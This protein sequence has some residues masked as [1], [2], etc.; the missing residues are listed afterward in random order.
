MYDVSKNDLYAIRTYR[1]QPASRRDWYMPSDSVNDSKYVRVHLKQ[2]PFTLAAWLSM[3]P[4]ILSPVSADHTQTFR[5][6]LP[7]TTILL[8]AEK[9]SA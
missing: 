3:G 2:T 8:S 4:H 5:S 9:L 6:S 7:E 1:W